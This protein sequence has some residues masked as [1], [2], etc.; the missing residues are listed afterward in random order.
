MSGAKPSSVTQKVFYNSPSLTPTPISLRNRIHI[1]S[2]DRHPPI[3]IPGPI[4]RIP[5]EVLSNVFTL[6]SISNLEPM[7]EGITTSCTYLPMIF[8]HVSSTW[9][10]VALSTPALWQRL[11]AHIYLY[12]DPDDP[13]PE[14]RALE[15]L[16]VEPQRINFLAWWAANMRDN[17]AFALRIKVYYSRDHALTHA[18]YIALGKTGISTINGLVS[19]ARYLHIQLQHSGSSPDFPPLSSIFFPSTQS[20]A[21]PMESLVFDGDGF[22]DLEEEF[23]SI[24]FNLM[25][26]L[27]KFRLGDP[28]LFMGVPSRPP[29]PTRIQ[30]RLE[31]MWGQ[32]THLSLEI[33]ATMEEWK[34]LI[35][36]CIAL[37]SGHIGLAIYDRDSTN[38]RTATRTL[39]NLRELFIDVSDP[40]PFEDDTASN[41]F[42][43]LYFPRLETLVLSSRALSPKLLHLM[44]SNAAPY[45]QRFHID[46][47]FPAVWK[48][49]EW[50]ESAWKM[51]DITSGV[52]LKEHLPHLRQLLINTPPV[53]GYEGSLA[54]YVESIVQSGWLNGPWKN[55]SLRLDLCWRPSKSKPGDETLKIKHLEQF[56]NSQTDTRGD[57]NIS[58]LKVREPLHG[59]DDV[60]LVLP[61]WDAWFDFDSHFADA[62][63]ETSGD[64]IAMMLP[65]QKLHIKFN[66]YSHPFW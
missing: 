54:E 7:C 3:L 46:S 33:L 37:E 24:P 23:Q 64:A 28:L 48:R 20:L 29:L 25:P 26:S 60:A 34:K 49:R 66:N 45:L 22:R 10:Q 50:A 8:C 42:Q 11:S 21:L 47:F 61:L 59:L 56:L 30:T 6:A 62:E 53:A 19:R 55:G 14:T 1:Q 44:I 39:P 40:W 58:L 35:G 63:G 31:N 38:S 9:R 12:G 2:F 36:T 5:H 52:H 51:E 17:T 41:I 57:V 27:R 15:T 65:E 18:P 4:N 43:D 32:L 13:S 16:W